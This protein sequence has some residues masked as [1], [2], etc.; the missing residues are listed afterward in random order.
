[1]IELV[2]APIDLS[3][4]RFAH[5]PARELVASI[6]CLRDPQRA[7][8]YAGWHRTITGRLDDFDPELLAALSPV[9]PYGWDF[10]S[11]PVTRQ[12]ADLGEE[13]D[14][15]AAAPPA[16]VRAELERY[17]PVPEPL[18]RLHKNPAR[19]LAEIVTLL[20]AYWDAAVAPVWA[21]VRALTAADLVARTEQFATGGV[22]AVLGQLH[23]E[24]AFHGDRIRVDKGSQ[25]V[26]RYDLTGQGVLLVPCVFTWPTLIVWCCAAE[27]PALLYPTR[28]AATLGEPAVVAPAAP[29]HAVLGRGRAGILA[30]LGEPRSTS[31]LAA[32]LDLSP[33]A[34]SQHLKA[35]RA[36]GLVGS[37]RRGREVLYHRTGAAASLLAAAD[38]QS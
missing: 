19:E 12:W 37:R 8:V 14:A 30:A 6:R 29:L 34:V 32:D 22:A 18:R 17:G 25:C 36:A 2:L 5:S 21:Q 33:S 27:Q 9:G 10:L 15:I 20:A 4:V 24:V 7:A 16:A 3:R 23:G 11:P 26:H 31:R 1:V 35:L 13:L 28:G 38:R